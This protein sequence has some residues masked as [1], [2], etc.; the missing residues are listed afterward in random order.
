M[1]TE[2]QVND[3]ESRDQG[4]FSLVVIVLLAAAI[5]IAVLYC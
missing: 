2:K 5:L 3:R 1:R 4:L